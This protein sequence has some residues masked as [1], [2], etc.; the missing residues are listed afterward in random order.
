MSTHKRTQSI[1]HVVKYSL[2]GSQNQYH[3]HRHLVVVAIIIIVIVLMIIII[4]FLR[5]CRWIKHP[6]W[7]LLLSL[8]LMARPHAGLEAQQAAGQIL[9]LARWATACASGAIG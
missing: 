3:P 4:F 8:L 7:S 1:K 6:L 9:S 2:V 5:A